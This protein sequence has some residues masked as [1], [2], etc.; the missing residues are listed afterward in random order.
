MVGSSNVEVKL[1]GPVQLY[2]APATVVAVNDKVC[3]AHTGVLLPSG[4]GDVGTVM[5]TLTVPVGP[6]HPLT[7]AVTE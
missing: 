2:V 4:V 1:F 7:V 5:V 3:P 6:A